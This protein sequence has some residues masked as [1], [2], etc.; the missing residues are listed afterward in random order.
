M[1]KTFAHILEYQ[2]KYLRARK[3]ERE[4]TIVNQLEITNNFLH[5]LICYLNDWTR[6]ANGRAFGRYNAPATPSAD[7]VYFLGPFY[8]STRWRR[9]YS[10]WPI[11][12]RLL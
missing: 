1:T 10:P 12:V 6:Y 8:V 7:Q 5:S 4:N 9:V 11:R 3:R 2:D